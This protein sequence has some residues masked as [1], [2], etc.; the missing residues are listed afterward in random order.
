MLR[1]LAFPSDPVSAYLRKGEIKERYFNPGDMFDQ[2]HLVT[3]ARQDASPKE[4]QALAGRAE[5]FIHPLGRVNPLNLPFFCRT[6]RGLA[7]EIGPDLIRAHNPW[8]AGTLA[9]QAGQG[10]PAPT[11]IYLHI[12]NDE[13]RLFDPSLRFRLVRPLERYSLSRADLV[14]CV[15]KFLEGYAHRHGAG[16]TATIYNKVFVDQFVRPRPQSLHS[17]LRIL[18][19]G[20]LDPQK[21]P[22][23]IIRALAGPGG[24]LTAELT[25]IGDGGRRREL[26]SLAAELGLSDR[27]EFIPSVPNREIQRYYHRA[28]V[29]A[30]ATNYEGFCIP[31]LEAMASGLPVVACS[32]PP[33]PEIVGSAGLLVE[34][35]APAFRQALGRLKQ[36]PEL[37]LSLGAAASKRARQLDGRIMEER[38]VRLYREIMNRPGSG[39]GAGLETG[40]GREGRPWAS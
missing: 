16:R 3:L 30:M 27:V 29:F 10:R 22:E 33:L 20:R 14:V 18:Y 36:E 35:S 19:V 12:D 25:I 13:R 34:L 37:A 8:L 24:R 6:V 11:L 15:S 9:V 1:L 39:Q 38:E 7:R 4:V 28:D 5:L 26:E 32:T 17:P 23:I 2:V 21:A 40:Q 31:V